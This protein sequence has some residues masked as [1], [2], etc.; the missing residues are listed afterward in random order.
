M[1]LN[2]VSFRIFPKSTKL[3]NNSYSDELWNEYKTNKDIFNPIDKCLKEEKSWSEDIKLFGKDTS[4]CL[5]V[6]FN[7]E[8]NIESID[9]RVD[10]TIP[11]KLILE[12]IIWLCESNNLVIT[13]EDNN[14][15]E[16]KYEKLNEYILGSNNV[17]LGNNLLLIEPYHSDNRSL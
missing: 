7:N 15:I 2:Q 3:K 4:S 12:T 13:D 10:Y 11:Y 9:F 17:K 14:Q 16:L 6:M 8:E 5:E 1:A